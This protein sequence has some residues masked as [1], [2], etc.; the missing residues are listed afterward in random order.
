MD[1]TKY[2]NIRTIKRALKDYSLTEK[3]EVIQHNISLIQE[4]IEMAI[5]NENTALAI[6]KMSQQSVFEDILY[7]YT[8][9][10]ERVMA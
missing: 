9:Q 2:V 7:E 1:L 10:L 5:R 8:V 3:C 4:E 6:W